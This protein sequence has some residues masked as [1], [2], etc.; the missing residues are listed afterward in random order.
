[1]LPGIG[2]A[3][4]GGVVY[5]IAGIGVYR[6]LTLAHIPIVAVSGTSGGAIVGSAIAA[7]IPE[8]ELKQV[9]LGI[10]WGDLMR[11]TPGRMGFLSGHPIGRFVEEVC[12][13]SLIEDLKMPF[14]AVATDIISGEEVRQDHGPLGIA[15]QAS[16]AIPGLFQPVRVGERLLV[17]GGVV[18]NLPVN[19]VKMH[20]PAV[21]VAVDVLTHSD[22]FTGTIRN[23]AF[24]VLKAY[25]IMVKRIGLE[26][27]KEA[28]I[29]MS[30]DVSGC[31]VL[32]F[33]YSGELIERGERA[34][35]EIVP[36][37]KELLDERIRKP[38]G[39]AAW[40]LL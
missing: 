22:E 29:I 10:R 5:S 11:F 27:E 24:V 20:R 1:M 7:G 32:N 28:D 31:S 2:L 38:D 3:L 16:C 15:V 19:A 40:E 25:H 39:S 4:G 6:A 17:D 9:A 30:P 8:W 23:G 35:R 37:L 13:C 34:G 21:T 33:R 14:T 26:V 12:G 36:R 18:D